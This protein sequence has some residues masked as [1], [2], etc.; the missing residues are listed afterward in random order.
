MMLVSWLVRMRMIQQL[1][2]ILLLFQL[3]LLG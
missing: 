1:V 3:S 2:L